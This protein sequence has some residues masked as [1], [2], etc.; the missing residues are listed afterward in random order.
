MNIPQIA[1]LLNLTIWPIVMRKMNGIPSSTKCYREQ[2]SDKDDGWEKPG[3]PCAFEITIKFLRKR[4]LL[5][6]LIKRYY[7]LNKPLT[8]PI[9]F[10]QLKRR[11]I[12]IH[13]MKENPFNSR[14]IFSML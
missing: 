1:V 7:N 2:W 11:E 3:H 5:H 13:F 10:N 8:F 6:E 12:V 14:V 9:I 4:L